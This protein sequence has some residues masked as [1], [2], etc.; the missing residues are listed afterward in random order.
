MPSHTSPINQPGA[1]TASSAL[2]TAGFI[3]LSMSAPIESLSHA[4]N[5]ENVSANIASIM[6]MNKGIARNLFVKTLS[7]LSLVCASAVPFFLLTASD[8]ALSI[9]EYLQLAI[10]VSLSFSMTEASA[11]SITSLSTLAASSSLSSSAS[12]TSSSFSSVFISAQWSFKPA[13]CT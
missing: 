13:F 7:I 10:I 6:S 1:S 9:Y 11:Y 2:A 3:T 5:V 4:P 8:T 12:M